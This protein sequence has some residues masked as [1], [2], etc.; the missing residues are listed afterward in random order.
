M[1]KVMVELK[2]AQIFF[3]WQNNV[4]TSGGLFMS[5][6]LVFDQFFNDRRPAPAIFA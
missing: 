2:I 3:F 5:C 4:G 1:A 6:F